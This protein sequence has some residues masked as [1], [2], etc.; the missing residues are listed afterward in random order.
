MSL[1]KNSLIA[2]LTARLKTNFK[3]GKEQEWTSDKAAEELAKAIGD[4]VHAY[5]KEAEVQGVSTDV[6]DAGHTIIGH[7]AQN[8][9]VKLT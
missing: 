4:T 9:T 2:A 1:D 6:E 8:N 3:D 7:G 5:V